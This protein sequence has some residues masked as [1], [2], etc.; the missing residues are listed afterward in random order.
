MY[1]PTYI[2]HTTSVLVLDILHTL[3]GTCIYRL[4][5]LPG[6]CI[7]VS[8]CQNSSFFFPQPTMLLGAFCH[9]CLVNSSISWSARNS[10]FG[11]NLTSGMPTVHCTCYLPGLRRPAHHFEALT[12]YLIY[13]G[14]QWKMKCSLVLSNSLSSQGSYR[15]RQ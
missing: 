7:M 12:S 13:L 8:V 3:I 10:Y 4:L 9:G 2:H 15:F 6:L 11:G 14:G 5:A 1:I